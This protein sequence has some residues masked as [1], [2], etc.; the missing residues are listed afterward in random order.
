MG[1][2][3]PRCVPGQ[4]TTPPPHRHPPSRRLEGGAAAEIPPT[5][6][7]RHLPRK[8]H[9][10]PTRA[11]GRAALPPPAPRGLCPAAYADSGGGRGGARAIGFIALLSLV[12]SDASGRNVFLGLRP[13]SISTLV[14]VSGYLIRRNFVS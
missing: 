9:I 14:F 1:P 8:P 13:S 6:E 5:W 12:G 2:E 10:F 7:H 11:R 4:G 3:Q